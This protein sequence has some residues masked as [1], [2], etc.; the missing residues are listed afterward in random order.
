MRIERSSC[1]A[2]AQKR[3][4]STGALRLKTSTCTAA[5]EPSTVDNETG[6]KKNKGE[7]GEEES[8]QGNGRRGRGCGCCQLLLSPMQPCLHGRVCV[9]V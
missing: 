2:L 6:G 9:N 4:R 1:A 3:G 7:D 5:T 8:R